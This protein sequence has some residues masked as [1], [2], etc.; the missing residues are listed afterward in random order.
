MTK[1]ITLL[2]L[3]L[4]VV[5]GISTTPANAQATDAT[6]ISS[7][8]YFVPG[9]DPGKLSVIFY[10]GTSS[11][12]SPE[13]DVTG[14]S[15]GEINIGSTS[16][17]E[18]FKGTAVLSSSVPVASVTTQFEENNPLGFSTGFYTGFTKEDAGSTFYLSTVRANGLTSSSIGVQNV[19]DVA[20]TATLNFYSVFTGN[21]AF[22]KVVELQPGAGYVSKL[23][24]IPEFSG[25]IFDGSLVVTAVRSDDLTTP[26]NV[27]ASAVET[28]DN[29][30]GVYSYQG[31]KEGS[32]KVYLPTAMC[33]Y[34]EQTSYFAIQNLGTS[35]ADVKVDYYDFNNNFVGSTPIQKIS[36]GAKWSTNPC[37]YNLLEQQKG[38]AVVTSTNG[39]PLTAMA[40]I[41]TTDGLITAFSGLPAGSTHIALPYVRWSDNTSTKY[42]S[43]IAV[44]NLGTTNATNI[45]AHYYD[46]D[47]TLIKTHTLASTSNPLGPSNKANTNASMANALTG[48]EFGYASNG[49]AVEIISDQPVAVVVRNAIYPTNI[50][51]INIFGEDYVGIRV[52]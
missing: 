4:V 27:V 50:P 41:N 46:A 24:E 19:E 37:T 44:M 22:K 48:G 43:Y 12:T 1:K 47:G 39:V 25:S 21:L 9:D 45:I 6:W 15:S 18:N 33:E 52:P 23:R 36:K 17:S 14:K 31:V 10:D 38:S 13:I 34:Q 30:Y 32:T 16:L 7:I 28:Q 11:Y 40:K 51:G 20:I 29:G 3:L 5:L 8:T 42:S 49:G 35:T 2:F 26:A